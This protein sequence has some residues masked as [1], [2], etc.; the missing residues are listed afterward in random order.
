MAQ[1]WQRALQEAVR[2]ID[3]LK[4]YVPLTAQEEVGLRAVVRRFPMQIPRSYLQ[5][6]DPRD[7]NDPIRSLVLPA[8]EELHGGG[9]LDTSGEAD[10]TRVPGLQH[11]YRATALILGTNRCAAYCRYCFRKRLCDRTRPSSDETIHDLGPAVEYIRH[12]PEISNV[13]ISGGDPLVMA[14]HRLE[15]MLSALREIDHI[16]IIRIGSKVPVFLP[17]RITSDPGLLDVLSRHS[18]R[19]KRL[20]VVTH[21][22]HPRELTDE[23]MHA[24]ERLL[25]AGVVLANQAVLLRGINDNPETLRDLF[26]RL[27]E[28]GV[29]PYYLFQCRPVTGS[30]HS[31]VP[32]ARGYAIVEAAKRGCSGLAK[33]LRY[34]MSHYSG[35]VEI[36]G[37]QGEHLERRI[38]LKYHQARDPRDEGRFFSRPLPADA[39]WLDDLPSDEALVRSTAA[40]AF[41]SD[42][43]RSPAGA[44]ESQNLLPT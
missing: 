20:Y 24:I 5:L 35:K 22:D 28:A 27:A 43:S 18:S 21:V 29:A 1:L 9:M 31:R 44:V 10:N 42:R 38:Y 23:A 34:A 6:I 36:V 19:D 40:G 37:V 41:R 12:H 15:E 25:E 39:C 14:N 4:S 26:N 33:R 30:L 3:E 16:R 2:S 7:P 13:L 11:K 8:C 17:I 32:L